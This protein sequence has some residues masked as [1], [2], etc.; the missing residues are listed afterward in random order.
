MWSRFKC[1]VLGHDWQPDFIG[2]S[3][4]HYHDFI[5]WCRRCGAEQITFDPTDTD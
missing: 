1:L 3:G 2:L 5:R 4:Y